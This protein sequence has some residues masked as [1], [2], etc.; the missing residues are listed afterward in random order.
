MDIFNLFPGGWHSNC[1][2]LISGGKERQQGSNGPFPAAV[3][4]PSASADSI[5]HFLE[6]KNASLEKIILTHG[7]FDHIMSLDNLRERTDAAVY[8]HREDNEM[9][10]DGEK[11]AYAFFFG[12]D[13]AWREADHL[14]V[15]GEIVRVGDEQLTVIS[16][17]GHSKGSICLLG[18]DF[19]FTGD[20]L[21]DGNIGRY[22]LHGG[23]MMQLY[24]SLGRLT[25]LDPG[26]TIYPGHG[27]ST[28]LG[29]ALSG[30][31]QF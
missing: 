29:R 2:I 4:D 20:T 30:L 21:F 18:E 24:A 12:Q 9:L 10:A 7:H 25:E 23:N 31:V 11:N 28:A 26:L 5:I 6:S 3:I 14:L 17:P 15:D 27:S 22:D 13:R 1:Y 8:I 19:I 16:T